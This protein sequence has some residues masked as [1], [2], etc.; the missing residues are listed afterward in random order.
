VR[1]KL[2][3]RVLLLLAIAPS[4]LA[5]PAG[6]L[7]RLSDGRRM[8]LNCSGQG[9]PTVI[10]EG[11]YAAPGSAWFKVQP[12]VA[13]T[14][15]V[16]SYDRAGY[17][18]SDPG[19]MPRDGVAVVKDLNQAL[20]RAHVHGPFVLVGH[21]VG[22]LYMRI[23]ADLRPKDV[24]GMVLVDPSAAYQDQRF[25]SQFGPG[26]GSVA[27]LRNRAQQCLD[28]VEAGR[29]PSDDLALK[30]C[31]PGVGAD[32]YR[33]QISELDTIWGP[34]SDA[35]AHGRES[36][37]DMPMIV[38]TADRTYGTGPGAAV[39]G[40]FWT[41]LHREMAQRSTRGREEAVANSGHMMMFDRPDAIEKAINEV[42]TDARARH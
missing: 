19:P 12:V 32:V 13:Q 42:V 8:M 28:A 10:L 3:S 26:A 21:S 1:Y 39:V 33:T 27:P 6:E 18:Q 24:V 36:Y 22:A 25:A 38:L 7:V 16:C 14:T 41:Q 5:A 4:A 29:L 9:T 37:G 34:T 17:G 20:D 40:A 2:L 15:R 35:V 30:A 11:G 23:F 31:Q